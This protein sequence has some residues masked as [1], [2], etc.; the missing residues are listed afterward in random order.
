MLSLFQASLHHFHDG[1]FYIDFEKDHIDYANESL[2][3]ILTE[4]K[5]LLSLGQEKEALIEG[6]K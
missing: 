3:P 1:I 4:K 6:L 2:F 5:Y